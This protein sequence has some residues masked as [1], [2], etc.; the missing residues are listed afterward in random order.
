MAKG[1]QKKENIGTH[2]VKSPGIFQ[3]LFFWF[4]IPLLFGLAIL[5]VIA[6]VF[7]FNV[8]EKAAEFTNLKSTEEV[9]VSDVTE[10]FNKKI[11]GLE[12]EVKEKEAEIEKLQSELE[13]AQ[14]ENQENITEQEQLQYEIEKLQRDQAAAQQEFESILQSFEQMSAKSA[15]PILV[16]MSDE[17]AVKIL[18][19]MKPDILSAILA[20]MSPEDA[21]RYTELLSQ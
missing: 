11:V 2:E 19:S 20:K 18:A 10:Q 14:A 1:K 5:L 4:I 21:A 6:T 7:N 15:A 8:F 9:S 16:A 13:K 3:K 12:A 17:E